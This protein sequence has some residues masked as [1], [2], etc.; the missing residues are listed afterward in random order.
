MVSAAPRT[1]TMQQL[2]FGELGGLGGAPPN[3]APPAPHS[4]GL[5]PPGSAAV[6]VKHNHTHSYTSFRSDAAGS[7]GLGSSPSSSDA[8]AAFLSHRPQ[9]A[10]GR[11]GLATPEASPSDRRDSSAEQKQWRAALDNV[12]DAGVAADALRALLADAVYLDEDA[13]SNATT[14]SLYQQ[15]VQV[16]SGMCGSWYAVR[17]CSTA[18][19]ALL[20]STCRVDS[21]YC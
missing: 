1:L 19:C 13:F 7:P 12:R 14:L 4:E 9:P 15:R 17:T 8:P 20:L 6:D 21:C 10:A 2:P 3:T 11:G 18:V 5:R 16:R